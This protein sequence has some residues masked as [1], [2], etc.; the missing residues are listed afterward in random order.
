M[1]K[2]IKK[3]IKKT[4]CSSDKAVSLTYFREANGK[5]DLWVNIHEIPAETIRI[6]EKH[7]GA[8]VKRLFIKCNAAEFSLSVPRSVKNIFDKSIGSNYNGMITIDPKNPYLCCENGIIYAKSINPFSKKLR[9]ICCFNKN[10]EYVKL[11]RGTVAVGNEVFKDCRSLKEVVLPPETEKI[12]EGAFSGCY[13]LERINLE[14][15]R[16]IGKN[17]FQHC[18]DLDNIT[19]ACR[20][21]REY[22]FGDC[23]SLRSFTL[24]NTEII[25]DMAFMACFFTEIKLPETLKKI[26][27]SVF[28]GCRF[29]KLHIPRNVREIVADSV[30]AREIELYLTDHFP[31]DIKE[32][33][34]GFAL[35][36]VITVLSPETDEILFRFINFEDDS[37]AT[38]IDY[39]SSK[40]ID[41]AEYDRGFLGY[42][43][44]PGVL[45][46]KSLAAFFRLAYP[47]DLTEEMR[48]TYERFPKENAAELLKY[49]VS[50]R[51]MEE[52]RFFENFGDISDSDYM[53]I[54]KL[55][56]KRGEPEITALVL[57]KMHQAKRKGIE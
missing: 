50:E 46:A 7:L 40:G 27:F 18:H 14:N 17:A 3:Y 23:R 56:T 28:N 49:I 2:Y 20:V 35:G 48:N 16:D 5:W 10:I 38:H 15:V 30:Y 24:K 26:G 11:P 33:F 13:D 51:G 41:L 34:P 54:V 6:P 4:L 37:D 19:I 32:L 42:P 1:K 47:V 43:N 52:L 31:I 12:G 44:T 25:E 8:L 39:M 55:A 22:T 53:E 45:Y 36:Q 29:E 57:Q 21:I 9:A